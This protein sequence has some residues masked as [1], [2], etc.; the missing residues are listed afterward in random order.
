LVWREIASMAPA[1]SPILPTERRSA[2]AFSIALG[3]AVHHAEALHHLAHL[4]RVLAHRRAHRFDAPGG[5]GQLRA[6]WRL[7]CAFE[8]I[9]DLGYLL[10]KFSCVKLAFLQW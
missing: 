10:G 7:C 2:S 4:A 9:H 3:G 5:A 1:I 6:C 8:N